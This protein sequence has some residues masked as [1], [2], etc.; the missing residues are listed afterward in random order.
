MAGVLFFDAHHRHAIGATFRR[1][2]EIDNFGK[3]LLQER[4]K[5]FIQRHA[6]HRRLIGRFA[7][8]GAVVNRMF[9]H[10]DAFHCEHRKIILLVVI[11]GVVAIRAFQRRFIGVDY[12][13]EHNFCPRRHLQIIADTFH[14]LRA[15]AAQQAGKLV[16]AQS[17]RHRRN[18]AQNGGRVATEHHRHR[19]RHARMRFFMC[20]K[21]QRA[22][23]VR[24]PAH[25][26][27]VFANHLLPVNAQI[28]ALFVRPARHRQT[29][30]HQRRNVFRPTMLNRQHAQIHIRALHHDFLTRRFFHHMRR[31]AP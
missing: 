19:I 11:A 21:I 10:G 2:I 29:P 12:A 24:Q 22:T 31:H 30:G 15:R 8:V 16:F 13:F 27:L 9:T 6:Q 18:R 26:Q 1:Q 20:L 17:V 3:L 7:G 14:Q 28:L 23:T 4:H 25:N 5:H